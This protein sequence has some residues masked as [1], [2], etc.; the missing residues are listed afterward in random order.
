MEKISQTIILFIL[1]SFNCC[2]IVLPFK[3]YV[4][5]EPEIFK[6]IDLI[7][8]WG[9]NIIYSETLIGTPPQK[10]SIIINSQNFGTHLFKNMCDLPNSDF[11]RSKSSSFKY[12]S[13]T[14]YS[15]IKN[16]SVINETIYF[17]NSLKLEKQI[18]LN[19]YRIIYSDN[20]ESI[21]EYHN[22]TC[23]D[24]G[25]P[26]RWDNYMD[27]PTNLVRQLK[28]NYKIIETFDI[29]FKYNSESEGVIIIGQ[30]PHLYDPENYFEMQYRI[31]GA[32]GGESLYDWYLFPDASYISLKK[33]INGTIEIINEPIKIMRALKIKFDFGLIIGTDEYRKMIKKLFFDNLITEEKCFEENIKKEKYG[34]IFIYYCDKKLTEDLIQNEFPSIYF[35]VKQFNKTFELTYK[36]LFR[37]KDGKLYFLIYFD[38]SNYGPFFTV[39][40]IF[41]KKYFFT[42]NQ[43]T[44]MIGYYNEDLPGGKTKINNNNNNNTTKYILFIVVPILIII[45]GILGFFV[46]KFVYDSIR[47]KR[48]NE[49]D[50]NYDYNPQQNNNDEDKKNGLIINE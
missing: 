4:E 34:E 11:E 49:I 27:V 24:L 50:D 1:I 6:P 42:F 21:Y 8:Y 7:N 44:K 39:G 20:E 2:I 23:I 10:I 38:S 28:S 33:E 18:P 16:T 45:F 32:Y 31:Y 48:I 43:D 5:K 35:N 29:S 15:Q 14:S 46:G 36:D 9:K 30:E 13:D 40:S 17:Y 47:K 41:L 25:L 26:L 37:E 19:F 12:F 22:N 3:T